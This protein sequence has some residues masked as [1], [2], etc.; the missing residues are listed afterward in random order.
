MGG[1][2]PEYMEGVVPCWSFGIVELR[3]KKRLFLIE[4]FPWG[5]FEIFESNFIAFVL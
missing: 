1:V 5:G 3:K 2:V 4:M